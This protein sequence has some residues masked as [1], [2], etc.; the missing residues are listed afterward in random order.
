MKGV[1]SEIRKADD[2][3]T[4]GDE[5][6]A[7]AILENLF[8]RFPNE[9]SLYGHAINIYL[10][11]KMFDEAK[12]VF[13]L[14]QRKFGTDLRDGDFSLDEII[15]EQNE[16]ESAASAYEEAEVKV[17]RRMSVWERGR[18]SGLSFGDWFS[19]V[20]FGDWSSF[21][22]VKE[23]QLSQDGIVLKRGNHEYRFAWSDIQD[24]SI[25]T[26]RGY[27]G[28]P[29]SEPFIR[30]LHRKTAEQTFNIDVSANYPDFKYNALL[31]KELEKRVT[32]R[33]DKR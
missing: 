24:A 18:A 26:R 15:R 31:L 11:G 29:F 28:S 33:E 10:A 17:F 14:Y 30:T 21:F 3:M 6:A 12:G 25:T 23:I 5:A 7:R 4:A 22:P 16:F 32:L 20:P 13:S 19:G 1:K 9:K 2:A 8:E 27:K